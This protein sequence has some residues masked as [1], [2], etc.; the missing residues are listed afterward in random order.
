MAGSPHRAGRRWLARR[1]WLAAGVAALVIAGVLVLR[2]PSPAARRPAAGPAPVT[3][4]ILASPEVAVLQP[5]LD[6]VRD[7]TGIRV[8]L[9]RTDAV[10]ASRLV[11]EG[12]ADGRYD[13]VWLDS[14]RYLRWSGAAGERLDGGTMIATSPVLL[15]LR[16]S[17][18]KRLGWD[19]S[20]VT[21]R[22]IADAAGRG[23]F[24]FGMADPVRSLVGQ[25]AVLTATIGLSGAADGLTDRDIDRAA[26]ALRALYSAQTLTRPSSAELTDAYTNGAHTDG[27][28]TPVDGLFTYE[29]ELLRLNASGRLREPL[30]PIRPGD[31]VALGDSTFT[32]H[33]LLRPRSREAADAV[34]RLAG[35]LTT[36]AAQADIVRQTFYRP[37]TAGVDVSS[38]PT[39][40]APLF[41]RPFPRDRP[42]VE[43]LVA[44]YLNH[45]R[46]P[47]RTAFVLDV[48]GSMR[49]QR[50]GQ[51][52][53]AVDALA[54]FGTATIQQPARLRGR[55]QVVLLPFSST[56]HRPT[57]IDVPET[58]PGA[59][60]ARV[61]AAARGLDAGGNTAVYDALIAAYQEM[62]RL[63][64]SDPNRIDSIVLVT[65]GAT[66]RGRRL[67]DFLT[68]WGRLPAS[69][70][71]IPVFPVLVGEA[72]ED[73]MRQVAARTGGDVLDARTTDLA[74]AF[75]RLRARR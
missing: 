38:L 51:L 56:P 18:M 39:V 67:A 24:T 12:R 5:V 11:T 48:S 6:R 46:R 61:R 64:A 65:D 32:L 55:E 71:R 62:R 47:G 9:H 44:G 69:E 43:Q 49:G 27:P 30:H 3:V 42:I 10:E 22:Q 26:A 16:A 17:T 53:A 68:H 33:A 41:D 2:W 21:W 14:D 1:R 29:A 63:A 60:L 40:A 31:G 52:R 34:T 70:Q 13:G 59:A 45:Y 73:E 66:N 35:E 50:I 72:D 37:M 36:P 28:H 8:E 74:E 19:S 7:R 57:V 23:R 20:P 75:L 54:G 25:S 58:A 15:G 4:Q